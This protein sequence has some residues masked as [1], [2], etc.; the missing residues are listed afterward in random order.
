MK[1]EKKTTNNNKIKINM[2]HTDYSQ[3][4]KGFFINCVTSLRLQQIS[5]SYSI[6]KQRKIYEDQKK[7]RQGKKDQDPW[8]T[9]YL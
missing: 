6:E 3:K 2:N 4:E 8:Q 9:K 5:K 7:K 1:K